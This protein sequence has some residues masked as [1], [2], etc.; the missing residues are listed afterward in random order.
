MQVGD[1]L[2]ECQ[3]EASALV[4]PAGIEPAETT[5]RFLAPLGGN[6]RTA[7]THFDPDA[8]FAGLH[9]DSNFAAGGAIADRVLDQV[10]YCLG[11]QLAVPEQ[12]NRPGGALILQAC[13][14]L[15]RDRIIHFR[16]LRREFADIE[17]VELL[18]PRES[19]RAADL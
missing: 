19:L 8:S 3:S 6:A 2:R 16:K 10:A 7:I 4:G 15:I 13:A 17:P 14:A 1:G 12:R 5:A 11:E 18:A 9:A